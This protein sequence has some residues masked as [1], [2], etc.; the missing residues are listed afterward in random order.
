MTPSKTGKTKKIIFY[1]LNP[2]Y[3]SLILDMTYWHCILQGIDCNGHGTHVAG[4]VGSNPY[5]VARE[6]KLY[7]V[8]A[9]NCMGFGS[10]GGIV[11]GKCTR[12]LKSLESRHR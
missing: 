3:M 2:M 9:L 11:A 12:V 1:F 4:T 8:R 10:I 7:G 6:A 5:G